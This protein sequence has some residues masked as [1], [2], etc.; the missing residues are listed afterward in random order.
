MGGQVALDGGLHI[1]M[2][3]MKGVVWFK[4][5]ENCIRVQAGMRW[6]DLLDILD[7]HDLSR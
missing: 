3:G 2:R 5:E 7:P 4:P 1:D 6:R